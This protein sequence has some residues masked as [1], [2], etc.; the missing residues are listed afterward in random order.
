MTQPSQSDTLTV[1]DVALLRTRDAFLRGVFDVDVFEWHVARI[2]GGMA[3]RYMMGGLGP[4]PL[5]ERP[6]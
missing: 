3:P 2:Y 4:H 6:E 1:E 5:N